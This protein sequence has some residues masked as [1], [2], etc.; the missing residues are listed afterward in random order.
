LGI[1]LSFIPEPSSSQS[2]LDNRSRNAVE[3]FRKRYR[4]HGIPTVICQVIRGISARQ[5]YDL[6]LAWFKGHYSEL[7][8]QHKGKLCLVI[9]GQGEVFDDISKIIKRMKDRGA[10]TV[11]YLI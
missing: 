10:M 5:K 9:D 2:G 6:N 7:K 4:S 3:E 1:C 8:G 11:I